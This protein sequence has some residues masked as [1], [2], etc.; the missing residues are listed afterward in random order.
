MICLKA[1]KIAIITTLHLFS[2]LRQ[3]LTGAVSWLGWVEDGDDDMKWVE[4]MMIGRQSNEVSES[5]I[6][7]E[8]EVDGR[9][10]DQ[11]TQCHYSL[12]TCSQVY[13]EAHTSQ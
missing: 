4:E 2:W 10:G 1:G 11:R 9:R 7:A 6:D 5:V 8:M 13:D 12:T 3:V